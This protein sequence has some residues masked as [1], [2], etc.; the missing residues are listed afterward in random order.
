MKTIPPACPEPKTGRIYWRSLEQLAETPE[1]R[2]WVEREF[3]EGASEWTDP[4]SRRHF[5]KIMS[6]S[7]LLGG[8]GLAGSGC[9]LPVEKIMPFSKMPENYIHG[10]PQFY[11]TAM[12]TRSGAIPLVVKSSDGRP[13]KIEGNSLHP[14]SN[15]GTDRYAQATLLSLYDPDRAARFTKGGISQAPEAAFDF[16]ATLSKSAQANGGQGL[17][18]LLEPGNSPSCRRLIGQIRERL[19]QARWYTHDPVDLD[20]HR[21]AASQAFGQPVMPYYQ[22]DKATIVVS[23]DCDFLG[24]EEDVHNNIRRF[25]QRRRVENTAAPLNRLYVVESLLSITGFNADHRLRLASGAVVQLAAALA[26]EVKPEGVAGVDTIGKPA[27]LDPKWISECAKDLLANRG[28]SLVV[29]GHRQPMAVHL[30]AHAINAALGNGGQT[31]V[32]RGAEETGQGGL[33]E[34]AQAL[35]AGQVETL[36][37]LGGNPVYSA[38][39]DLDWGTAQRKAKTVVRLGYYEDETFAQSDWHLPAAH[40]LESWG[41]AQTSDG[42]LVPIQP[43]IAP[44]FGGITELEVLA[45]IVGVGSTYPYEIARETFAGFVKGADQE[46]VWKRFLH[47]GFLPNSAAKPISVSLNNQGLSQALAGIKAATPSREQLEAVFHRDYSLDDGRYNNNGWLQELSDPVTKLVWDNVVMVSR[48][49]AQELGVKNSDL[50]EVKLGGRSVRGPIWVQPGQAD[51]TLG[52]ALGYGREKTGRVGHKVGFNVY[53]LRT[54]GGLH[55]ASGATLSATGQTYPLSCTQDHWSMEGRPVIREA[56]LDQ[57]RKRPDFAKN[58]KL[59]E[60]PLVSPLY[61]NPF[62]QVK[63]Q[64]LHQWG[65][66]IDLNLCVGC[67]ACMLACQS[68]NN[69]PIVGKDQIKR[70]R[71]MHWLRIDRYYAGDPAKLKFLDTFQRDGKEQFQDWI[72]DPQVVTQPMMCQHCEAAPCESVC[73]VNATVHDQEGLNLMVYNR[74]VG[75]RYCSN[76]CPYKVRRFNYFDFNKRPLDALYKGPFG[77]R[78]DDE[79]D[80]IKMIKN[81]DVTVRMRGVMEKCTFCVQ[82]IEQ[83][84]IAQ[85]VKAGASGDVVVPT[86]SFTT[87]CAQACPAGAIVFGNLQD[88]ESRVSKLKTLQRDY[89]LLEYLLTK[90]RLTYLAKVRNPNPAMPDYSEP[91]SLQAYEAKSGSPFEQEGEGHGAGAAEP[92]TEKGAR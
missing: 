66:S 40:F 53:P 89:T 10:V 23:L 35:N 37:V 25:A 14:D 26:A 54:S 52:L 45:R 70:G 34:L 2:Q 5:M 20:V 84:K 48:K 82:R 87:A 22:F 8:L 88:P 55:F 30:L 13:T 65:M 90:P 7:F 36:V 33:V 79:W 27:G 3:P 78:K 9:R 85:K 11:A 67:S 31:V 50:V 12:P 39:V 44:L 49:T 19:P 63:K 28:Q 64:G 60:P 91:L 83:A 86:D 62:D 68:E 71:E 4:V 74:C 92:A 6:A 69:V 72:D 15:G 16:L 59:E 57:Y 76:N 75:T 77:H 46:A 73:P 32:F 42:T 47:D 1:F 58:M 24:S 41:D 56:N 43:L 21:R 17:S 38:P 81:P 18:F 29:V 61:P 80:M 51:Y